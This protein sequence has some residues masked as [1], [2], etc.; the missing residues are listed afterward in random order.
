MRRGTQAGF[1]L[2]E[3]MVVVALIGILAAV[4]I[5]VFLGYT[6][7][8][9]TGEP[10][11]TLQ[12]IFRGAQTYYEKEHTPPNATA[13]LSQ[14]FPAPSVGPTPALGTCCAAGGKCPPNRAQWQ[15]DP[16]WGADGLDFSIDKSHYFNYA[17]TVSDNPGAQDG[18]N[19]FTASANGDLDCDGQYSTYTLLGAVD[20]RYG[21][22]VSSSGTISERH[23][24]E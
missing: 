15:N 17:Y 5:P 24:S 8:A 11:E 14:H 12:A 6:R 20:V 21:E 9:K 23:P 2:I 18:S 4:A 10:H 22:G 13:P 7:K 3:L 16:V 1:T 19:G